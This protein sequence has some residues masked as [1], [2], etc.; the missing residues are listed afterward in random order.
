[1]QNHLDKLNNGKNFSYR[2]IHQLHPH[3]MQRGGVLV[4]QVVVV[5][6]VSWLQ[7]GRVFDFFVRG[8]FVQGD[9]DILLIDIFVVFVDVRFSFGI[10]DVLWWSRV[11]GG[12]SGSTGKATTATEKRGVTYNL[13]AF[14][15]FERVT[16][17]E[18]GGNEKNKNRHHHGDAN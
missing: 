12:S 1:M 3:P 8:R 6:A 18:E 13:F 5:G 15:H 4:E 17:C 10:D 16:D 14:L 7:V 9:F 2:S 11:G